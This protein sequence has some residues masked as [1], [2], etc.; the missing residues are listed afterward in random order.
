MGKAVAVGEGGLGG[1]VLLVSS[2]C[3]EVSMGGGGETGALTQA[4]CSHNPS[5]LL[6]EPSRM[7]LLVLIQRKENKGGGE[8][9]LLPPWEGVD[10]QGVGAGDSRKAW[11][12]SGS[13]PWDSLQERMLGQ[14]S[15][16]KNGSDNSCFPQPRVQPRAQSPRLSDNGCAG[17]HI[18]KDPGQKV[19]GQRGRRH[20][21]RLPIVP[22]EFI[23][24]QGGRNGCS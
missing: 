2:G 8:G 13:V 15:R 5:S 21:T 23:T 18:R 1:D 3:G 20:L 22:V 11:P 12:P 7:C 24:M 6:P 19:Y 4:L 16:S 9:A 10:G 17:N 14:G